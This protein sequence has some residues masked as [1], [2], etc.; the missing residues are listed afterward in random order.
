MILDPEGELKRGTPSARDSEQVT[1]CLYKDG[2][3]RSF[4][5]DQEGKIDLFI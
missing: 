4:C 1:L 5:I 2:D 3:K